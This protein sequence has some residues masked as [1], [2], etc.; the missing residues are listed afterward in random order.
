MSEQ[1]FRLMESHT[2]CMPSGQ[3]SISQPELKTLA[4]QHVFE[5]LTSKPLYVGCDIPVHLAHPCLISF[6]PYLE[7]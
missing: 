3:G 4:S 2:M 7:K 5:V 1:T 6:L